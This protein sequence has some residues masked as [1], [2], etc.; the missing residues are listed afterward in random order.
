V[1]LAEERALAGLLAA[2]ASQNLVAA[3]H[4]LAEGGLAQTLAEGVLRFGIGAR[5]WLDGILERDEVDAATALFSESTARMLVAVSREED[6]KFVGLCAGRRVPALRL[7][8]TDATSGTLEVQDR[9]AV[10]IDELRAVHRGTLPA[11]L[12]PAADLA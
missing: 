3:A 11:A 6:V 12:G 7:G 4:D 2:A 5:V 8:V 10:P 9:Y 1:R